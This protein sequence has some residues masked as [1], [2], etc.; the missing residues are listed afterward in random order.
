[1]EHTNNKELLSKLAFDIDGESKNLSPKEVFGRMKKFTDENG[2][3]YIPVCNDVEL[4]ESQVAIRMLKMDWEERKETN[5]LSFAQSFICGINDLKDVCKKQNIEDARYIP[6]KKAKEILQGY[7][8]PF[9][10]Y[11]IRNGK[12]QKS[13]MS[14]RAQRLLKLLLLNAPSVVVNNERNLLLA[15]IAVAFFSES[16][17]YLIIEK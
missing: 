5:F 1:M 6:V 13:V 17:K 4:T 14:I 10:H 16:G 11:Y 2:V 9:W 12:M 7:L 8:F 15:E 3:L